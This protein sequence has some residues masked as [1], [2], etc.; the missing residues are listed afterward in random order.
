M[1]Q[2][3]MQPASLFSLRVQ[4]AFF[5]SLLWN[6]LMYECPVAPPGNGLYIAF[7]LHLEE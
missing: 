1:K 3:I 4:A 5:A 6:L 2:K 7:H